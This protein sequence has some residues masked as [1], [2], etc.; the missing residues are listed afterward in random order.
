MGGTKQVRI[1]EYN[2]RACA[3]SR[4]NFLFLTQTLKDEFLMIF[5]VPKNIKLIIFVLIK[6]LIVSTIVLNGSSSEPRQQ[7]IRNI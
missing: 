6:S 2:L 3:N 7:C 5:S 4:N 1:L